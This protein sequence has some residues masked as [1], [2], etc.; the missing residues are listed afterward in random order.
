[1]K[2][3]IS[4]RGAVHWGTLKLKK[5]GVET[6]VLDTEVLLVHALQSLSRT[7]ER[8]SRNAQ[9]RMWL[10][11]HSEQHVSRTTAQH[12]SKMIAR[13]M[14]REPV[15]YIIGHKEFYGLDFFVNH[16]T[17]I[18]R[19]E[20]ETL[21]EETLK[22]I[23]RY[24]L[25]AT[26]YT[27]V[28]V[29]TGSGAI[30][31]AVAKKC[32]MQNAKCK[33][34]AI[35]IS[36]SALNVARKNAREN[37]VLKKI[38]FLQGNLLESVLRNA[39]LRMKNEELLIIANLPYLPTAE[40]RD[41]G[42]EV[43]KYEPRGALDGGRDGLKYY[44]ELLEQLKQFVIPVIRQPAEEIQK[45]LDP[46]CRSG[47]TVEKGLTRSLATTVLCEICPEQAVPFK[48][49]VRGFFPRAKFEIAKDLA[50]RNRVVIV[51][52]K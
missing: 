5:A 38:T 11:A 51:K 46:R 2:S 24:T 14:R 30:A 16:N 47:M 8:L 15:A 19:P 1:M 3:N 45:W 50:G 44:R 33:I 48:K 42:P 22:Q 17:L 29:G 41:A 12:F 34:I 20:T 18:P 28:D 40:W 4:V 26:R 7:T 31:V 13:R 25:H 10:Y 49:L 36:S 21:V 9:D 43:K 37:E 35:D 39:E 52:I 32:R 6:P 23:T 27:I